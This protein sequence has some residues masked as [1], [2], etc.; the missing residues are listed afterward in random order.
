MDEQRVT[1]LQE[2]PLF[3]ALQAA[4]L[5]ILLRQCPM[6]C[7]PARQVFFMEGEVARSMFF[8]DAGRAAVLK[9]L[10]E[11]PLGVLSP[12]DCFG[13]MSLID[14]QPRSATVRALTPCTAIEITLAGLEAVRHHDLGEFTLLH[15]NMERE[16]S[17]RLRAADQRLLEAQAPS[18]LPRV[19]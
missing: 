12:G 18:D 8:L 9:G 10:Q 13:E 11:Q 14:L 4:T 16:L 15:M 2:T 17:R 1:R 6:V 5:E 3:G 7:V 19:V